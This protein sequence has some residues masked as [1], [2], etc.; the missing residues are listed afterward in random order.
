VAG[1][2]VGGDFSGRKRSPRWSLA[3]W[4]LGLAAVAYSAFLMLVGTAVKPEVDVRIARP[5][6]GFLLE[7][8]YGGDLAVNR[9]SID[10]I[11]PARGGEPYSFNLGQ[12]IGLDGLLSL[13]PLAVLMAGAGWWLWRTLRASAVD[14]D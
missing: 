8:F 1:L 11:A 4:G 10:A 9:Q 7:R 12:L 2:G 6:G 14:A 5:F 13:L 3:V